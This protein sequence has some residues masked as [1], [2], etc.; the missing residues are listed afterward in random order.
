MVITVNMFPVS[1]R[2]FLRRGGHRG[3]VLEAGH[4]ECGGGGHH[5]LLGW[6]SLGQGAHLKA[7]AKKDTAGAALVL[8][9][10]R[11]RADNRRKAGWEL[12]AGKAGGAG[13]Q[14]GG[15]LQGEQVDGN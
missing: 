5:E 8:T 10:T 13:S 2:G 14:G 7:L 3:V 1:G 4:G 6:K 9:P 12:K 15:R 11:A